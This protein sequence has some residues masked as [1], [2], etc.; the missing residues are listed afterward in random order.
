MN[1]ENLP[2]LVW[3]LGSYTIHSYT[4]SMI[5]KT[6]H[7]IHSCPINS[8]SFWVKTIPNILLGVLTIIT[9]VRVVN[10]DVNSVSSRTQSEEFVA[11]PCDYLKFLNY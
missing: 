8:S 5:H 1:E 6:F 7:L 3:R 4:S 2:I 11:F 10:F 9:L